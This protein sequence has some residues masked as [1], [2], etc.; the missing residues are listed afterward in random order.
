MLY[1]G[2]FRWVLSEGRDGAEKSFWVSAD[3]LMNPDVSPGV[4]DA[5]KHIFCVQVDSTIKLVLLDVEIHM[6]SSF[7]VRYSGV[8]TST[9]PS[10][11]GGLKYYQYTPADG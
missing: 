1:W 9:L 5:D 8:A 7:D 2:K 6:A 11:G 3:V 4:K 10:F